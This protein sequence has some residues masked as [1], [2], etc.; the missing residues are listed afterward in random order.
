MKIARTPPATPE[1]ASGTRHCSARRSAR[2]V[3]RTAPR[4]VTARSSV[5]TE[6]SAGSPA[7]NMNS[8][9]APWQPTTQVPL[10]RTSVS[11]MKAA[12]SSGSQGN[13]VTAIS[14]RAMRGGNSAQI[15]RFRSLPAFDHSA[16]SADE[17]AQPRQ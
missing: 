16:I 1:S 8:A 15:A 13:R 5:S 2:G 10:R 9:E 4:A 7:P 6:I 3:K 12:T 17:R 11:A 14:S